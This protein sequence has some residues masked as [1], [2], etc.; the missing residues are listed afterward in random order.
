MTRFT[1]ARTLAAAA[2]FCATWAVVAAVASTLG[3]FLAW[4]SVAAAFGY[5]AHLDARATRSYRAH[6][7]QL[8]RQR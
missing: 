1:L 3:V 8:R 7:R 4:A 2:A 5:L 6:L